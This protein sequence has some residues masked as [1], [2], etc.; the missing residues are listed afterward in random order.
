[1]KRHFFHLPVILLAIFAL[2]HPARAKSGKSNNTSF[3]LWPWLVGNVNSRIPAIVANTKAIGMDAIYV[4]VFSVRG[5]KWGMLP[6][7]DESGKWKKSWGYVKPYLKLSLLIEKAHSAG[8]Q[9]IGVMSCFVPGKVDP[10]DI[11]HQRYLVENVIGYFFDHF[12]SNGKP[13]YEL[14]GMC[15]DYVRYGSGYHRPSKPVNDFLDRIKA[16]YPWLP[17]HAYIIA[18]AYSYDGPVY[19]NNFRSYSSVIKIISNTFGQ[20]YEEMAKRLDVMLPMA[21]IS[22]GG[23]YGYN[24]AYMKGYVR[25]VASYVRKATVRGGSP[26]TK[27]VVAIKTYGTADP[28]SVEASCSGALEGGADGF[29][30]FRYFTCKSSLYPYMSKYAI[31]GTNFPIISILDGTDGQSFVMDPRG[32]RDG[33]D[34]PSKLLLRYDFNGDGVFDTK[35]LPMG[36]HYGLSPYPGTRIVTAEVK[37]TEGNWARTR[38]EI[39]VGNSLSVSF[40]FLSVSNGGRISMPCKAG[41][42]AGGAFYITF[43]TLSGTKPGLRLPGGI[44]VPINYDSMTTACLG[45]ANSS[46]LPAW[47]GYLPPSGNVSPGFNPGPGQIPPAMAGH[48]I[49]FALGFFD[50]TTFFSIGATNPARLFLVK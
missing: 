29:D 28:G 33:Q 40:P 11:S 24:K 5:R 19:N 30:A 46:V 12:K 16:R 1:M 20:N 22:N 37:D 2:N 14:D 49:H 17:L 27:V 3:G 34:P 9:V 6:I 42:G 35:Y 41:K 36:V 25:C 43:A 50:P 47:I 32:S 44:T 31:P 7:E 23:V 38:R 48:E 21:Y 4:S 13:Y 15:L 26:S 18:N 10:T 45:L 8:L 39:F